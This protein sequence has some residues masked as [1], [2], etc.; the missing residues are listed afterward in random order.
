MYNKFIS[1]DEFVDKKSLNEVYIYSS[2]YSEVL[3]CYRC[4]ATQVNFKKRNMRQRAI[5]KNPWFDSDCYEA[6]CNRQRLLRM[7]R[8]NLT[9]ENYFAFIRSCHDFR[10][11]CNMKKKAL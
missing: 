5:L 3:K 6:K 1:F 10:L 9:N 2:L 8:K 11:L 7:L 4:A